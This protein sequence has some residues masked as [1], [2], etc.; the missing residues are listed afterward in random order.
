MLVGGNLYAANP[1]LKWAA[2]ALGQIEFTAFLST[3]LNL[4]HLFGHGRNTLILPVRARDE[5]KQHT[6]QESMF[7]Y[8]RL[9]AGGQAAPDQTLPSES[10]IFTSVAQELLC[11]GPVDW[12]KLTDHKQIRQYIAQTVPG[13]HPVA[14]LD[15]GREFTIPGRIRH[16]PRFGTENGKANLAVVEP[17]DCRPAAGH[18][19]LLTLR[20]EGQFNTI[21][22][23]EEDL[24]RG[25]KHRYV[26]LMNPADQR[27]LG[28]DEGAWVWVESEI[29][30]MKA[31]VAAS[32][33]RQG[34]VAMYYPEANAIV[35]ARVDPASRTPVFKR[36]SVKIRAWEPEAEKETKAA[37][38]S[39]T[40]VRND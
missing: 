14:D 8:V 12:T 25:V 27:V 31:Q 30:R 40:P 6:S 17:P 21:V 4:G 19:N 39:Q 24:Y 5:E 32:P 29:G 38:H 20:S 11:D 9:S 16:E 33:I 26:V 28:L 23:E 34:N 22:Y 36:V 15:N 35:P 18:F 1:D 3:T 10:E 13:L 7:N 2:A 37:K